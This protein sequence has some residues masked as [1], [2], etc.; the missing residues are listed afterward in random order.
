MSPV[1][2]QSG[3]QLLGRHPLA[4]TLFFP[5]LSKARTMP[6]WRS[7]V[8]I[9]L[10]APGFRSL[11]VTIFSTARTTPSLHRIPMMVPPFSTAFMAYSTYRDCERG[12]PWS[13]AG[14]ECTWKLRPSGEK[15]EFERS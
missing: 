11:L 2:R 7:A 12:R 4:K 6:T 1:G 3:G 9:F 8:V 5:R 10:F 15:T 14:E 13:P